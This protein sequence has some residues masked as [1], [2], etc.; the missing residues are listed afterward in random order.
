MGKDSRPLGQ[1]ISD[2]QPIKVIR[3]TV[4][5]LSDP[6][7]IKDAGVFTKD[8]AYRRSAEEREK[9]EVEK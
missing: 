6:E 5:D 3:Q 7:Y 9:R 8:E 2:S 4:Q 1:R